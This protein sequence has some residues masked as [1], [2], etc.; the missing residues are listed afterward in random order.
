MAESTF[1]A[2]ESELHRLSE[3]LDLSLGGNGQICFIT[4]EA[5]AGKSTLA[6]EFSRRAQSSHSELLIAVGNCN[7]QMGIGDPY[8][9]FREILGQ[10]TGDVE[11]KLTQGAISRENASRLESFLNVSGRAVVDLGPDLI[12]IFL[13]GAGLVARASALVTGDTAWRKKLERLREERSGRPDEDVSQRSPA[14]GAQQNQIFEQ[15]TRLIVELAAQRPLVIV[16]DDLH[17][18][19]ESSTSLLFHL[20]RRIGNSRILVL[21][22]YRPEDIA[23][24]RGD[25]RH[26]LDSVVNEIK[27]LHGEVHL[28]LAGDDEAKG[29]RFIDALLDAQPNRLGEA[30][31]SQLLRHTRGQALFT[32]ELLGGMRSRGDLTVDGEGRLIE[33]AALDWETLPARI[34][35]V[36]EERIGRI[37]QDLQELLTVASVEGEVFTAQVAARVQCLGERPVLRSLERE[38]GQQHGL[39]HEDSV[40]RLGGQRLSQY[41]FRHNL[42]QR[43]LYSRLSQSERELLHESIA[44]ALEEIHGAASDEVAGQLARHYD[45]AQVPDKA[46][47]CYLAVGTRAM[48]VFANEEAANLLMR[49]LEL[50]KSLPDSTD[51]LE[52]IGRLYLALGKAQWKLGQAPESMATCQQ[53]AA[54]ARNIGSGEMLAQAALGYDDPR[55]RFNFPAEPA[56][57]LLEEALEALEE[58]NSRLRVRVISALVRAQG[59]RMH[60]VVRRSLVDHAVAMARGL[61]DPLAIYTALV[62]RSLSTLGPESIEERLATRHETV[63]WAQRIG[64]KAPLLDAY[65]YR[66]DDLLAL[67]DIE[68][69]D[70]DIRAMETVAGKLGEPFYDYCLTTK[71]AMRELLEGRFEEAE[72]HAQLGMECSQQMDVDNAAGVFGMQ[73]FSIR[74]LQGHLQ[75]LAPIISHFVTDRPNASCWRPGL[76]LIYAELGDESAARAEFDS[77]ARGGFQGV[78]RDSLWQTCLSFMSDVCAF[79]G[80]R[81]RASKL[82]ELMLPYA[83]LT[84][85]VGNSVSCNGAASRNLGQLAAVMGEWEKAQQHFEHALQFNERLKAMPWLA[86]ARHQY[87]R[88][89]L[90]RR[91]D[92][93]SER[94]DALLADAA[95]L[96]RLLKMHSVLE[97]I[98]CDRSAGASN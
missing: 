34:E 26:P 61:E 33:G 62:T 60:E 17:W 88:M 71:R 77:L 65:M 54:V 42:L 9:P 14:Q 3:I 96:A 4:G 75:G 72:R 6:S 79:L 46:A 70:A 95:S 92:G 98:Q 37:S 31:R 59:H 15:F 2:R 5:G 57:E 86:I 97:K 63:R 8:L 68:G 44:G 74:R 76:A 64:D 1:V 66:I 55:F 56:V 50:A 90:A 10:L 52:L 12:D 40:K 20:A 29:R 67:G 87:A 23:L 35:G 48:G 28:H 30:F 83:S 51:H 49:G 81:E 84:V 47:A 69:V 11:S 94:A 22:S 36:I 18:A 82:Y 53:A 13:P 21:G 45:L 25:R 89:L 58:E 73:M 93:D 7:A 85:V 39:V 80:D 19:D 43:Y 24:G 27:R 78:P 16:L 41:R 38:L 32:T 91:S